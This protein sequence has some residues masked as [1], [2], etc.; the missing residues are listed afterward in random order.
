M[1]GLGKKRNE[2][3][4]QNCGNIRNAPTAVPP[5]AIRSASP[6]PARPAAELQGVEQSL[7][8][9]AEIPNSKKKSWIL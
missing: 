3:K 7:G 1:L 5:Q 4:K 2:R 8:I 9:P 6:Q